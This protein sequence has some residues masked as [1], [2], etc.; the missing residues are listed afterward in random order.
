MRRG[1][2]F[3]A[4]VVLIGAGWSFMKPFLDD[5]TGKVLLAVLPLQVRKTHACVCVYVCVWGGGGGWCRAR[6][7]CGVAGVPLAAPRGPIVCS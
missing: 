1:V 7:A 6:R 4:V 5:I 3:F 2:L